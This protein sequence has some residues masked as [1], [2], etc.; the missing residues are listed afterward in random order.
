MKNLLSLAGILLILSL[1]AFAQK[2]EV[3]KTGAGAIRGYDPVAYFKEGQPVKGGTGLSFEWKGSV[4]LFSTKENLELFKAT[5][6]KYAPQYGG[7]CAYGTADG[8]KASTDPGAW[9]IVDGKL[10]LN[11]NKNVQSLWN[12]KQKEFIEQANN[13]WPKIKDKE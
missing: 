11:Y 2:S 4:W 10:Y 6:E 8:H 3:F 5:P 12:K 7:Y 9:T 1:Q 13:N